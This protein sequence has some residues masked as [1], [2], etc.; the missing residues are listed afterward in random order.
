MNTINRKR[1][2]R[3]MFNK[4][5]LM[6]HKN[7][8]YEFNWHYAKNNFPKNQEMERLA[9]NLFGYKKDD[10]SIVDGWTH[11]WQVVKFNST[12]Q[13]AKDNTVD[14]EMTLQKVDEYLASLKEWLLSNGY[15]PPDECFE[16]KVID[17]SP[18]KKKV[19]FSCIPW[20]DRYK[21]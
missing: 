12:L 4:I 5:T 11:K 8:D 9:K 21:V 20:L 16:L 19:D 17:R 3:V 14:I 10:G 2:Y 1:D 6:F 7:N 18:K 13:V 15:N